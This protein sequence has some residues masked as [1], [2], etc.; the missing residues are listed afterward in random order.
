MHRAIIFILKYNCLLTKIKSQLTSSCFSLHSS[1]I[2]SLEK[3]EQSELRVEIWKTEQSYCQPDPCTYSNGQASLKIW[4]QS[5]NKSCPSFSI[6]KLCWA[7]HNAANRSY[8]KLGGLVTCFSDLFTSL[9]F[10][11]NLVNSTEVPSQGSFWQLHGMTLQLC[12]FSQ[13]SRPEYW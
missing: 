8:L 10:K 2:F 1:M 5:R 7:D 4:K 6:V 11:A 3:Q 12:C 13:H 9:F